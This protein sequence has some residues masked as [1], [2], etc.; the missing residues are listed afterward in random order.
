MAPSA[1]PAHAHTPTVSTWV[2]RWA[3]VIRA[4]GSVL[5]LA[6]GGGRHARLLASAGHHVEAVDRDPAALASLSS[7]AEIHTRCADLEQ[8]AWPYE[9]QLFDGIVVTNYLHRPLLPRIAAA[10]APGGVLIYETFRVGNESYGKPSSSAFLLRPA[11]L[12]EFCLHAGLH[13]VAFEDGYSAVPKPALIQ[14]ICAVK[15]P[16]LAPQQGRLE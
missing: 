10:L 8:G 16:F 14:R 11:E 1:S 15:P 2:A 6:C 9:V 13:I 3:E 12:F 4:G 5:D 7:V